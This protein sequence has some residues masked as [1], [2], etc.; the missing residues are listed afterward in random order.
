MAT[1]NNFEKDQATME[2]IDRYLL[3]QLDQKELQQF[4]KQMEQDLN[5]RTLVL[6]QKQQMEAVEEFCLRQSMIKYGDELSQEKSSKKALPKWWAIAA[7][8]LVLIAFSLW[9]LL[10]ETKATSAQQIFAE[11]FTPDPG[12]PTTMG[13]SSDYEFYSGMVSYKQ[14]KYDEA[15]SQWAPLYAANPQ[16][17]TLTYFLGVANLAKGNTEQAEKYLEISLYRDDAAFPGETNY[18]L[19][20]TY[21]KEDKVKDAKEILKNSTYP[22]S[23]EL[24]EQVKNLE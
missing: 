17:D 5:F 16:N 13:T 8:G 7:S 6:E 1:N 9:V 2:M 4:H 24:F 10:Q 18:Y 11:N 14:K 20:L 23:I 12:L 3:E 15:I 19:A 21:L 22:K